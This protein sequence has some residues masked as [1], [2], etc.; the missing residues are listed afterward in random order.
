MSETDRL[1]PRIMLKNQISKDRKQLWNVVEFGYDTRNEIANKWRTK[2]GPSI[3]LNIDDLTP[4]QKADLMLNEGEKMYLSDVCYGIGTVKRIVILP[5]HHKIDTSKGRGYVFDIFG[6]DKAI[7]D[8]SILSDRLLNGVAV[9]EIPESLLRGDPE[10]TSNAHIIDHIK[11]KI[12][13]LPRKSTNEPSLHDF[14]RETL[15]DGP[16]GRGW[17]PG[18]NNDSHFVGLYVYMDIRHDFD[19]AEN[20]KRRYFIVAN[21]GLSS[22]PIQ[23]LRWAMSKRMTVRDFMESPEYKYTRSL[24]ERMIGRMLYDIVY[25]GEINMSMAFQRT[26]ITMDVLAYKRKEDNMH[27]MVDPDSISLY[28]Y[29]EQVQKTDGDH[30]LFY[31]HSLKTSGTKYTPFLKSPKSGVH[32]FNNDNNRKDDYDFN[33]NSKYATPVHNASINASVNSNGNGLERYGWKNDHYSAF[34]LGLGR[35]ISRDVSHGVISEGQH[36]L[37]AAGEYGSFD[38]E[39][40]LSMKTLLGPSGART[41]RKMRLSPI[42]VCQRKQKFHV[43]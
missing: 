42:T 28:N 8:P 36:K 30:F 23:L 12:K 17:I 26:R 32:L 18:L 2:Y 11:D 33:G 22:T 14:N 38:R 31:S 39:F 13:N 9:L 35:K 1:A 3:M 24:T 16:S 19:A 37:C 41:M 20:A 40:S 34:P 7:M 25:D 21:V 5:N 43:I 15:A 29:F 4:K 6:S 10:T 27:N